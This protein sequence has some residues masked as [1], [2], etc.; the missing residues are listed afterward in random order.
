MT[1]ISTAVAASATTTPKYGAAFFEHL[2]RG[3]GVQAV[4]FAV[5]GLAVYAF[6]PFIAAPIL[7]LA[8]L[9]LTWWAAAVRTTL[10]DAGLDG[11]GAAATAASSA[12]AGL[13]FVVLA[14]GVTTASLAGTG[15][16]AFVSGL[17][18]VGSSL[19]VLSS[20]PRA[21]LVMAPTFGFWRAGLISNKQFVVGVAL[22]I[23]GVLGGTTWID[24]TIWAPDG[25]FARIIWPALGLAFVVAA[26]RVQNR[27]PSTKTGF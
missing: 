9:N 4:G 21:M 12:V 7:G 10:A 5:V 11:W 14:L 17:N 25:V 18:K 22:V 24:G 27:A 3:A 15:N 23:L 20:F 1:S 8:I 2:W 19:F 6:N 13:L 16:D 26:S